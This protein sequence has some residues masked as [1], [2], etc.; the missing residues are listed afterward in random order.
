MQ[1]AQGSEQNTTL[2]LHQGVH[3]VKIR[4]SYLS[5][6]VGQQGVL[7][8]LLAVCSGLEL[9]QVAVVVTLHL[10][11]EDLGLPGRGCGDQVVIQ[12]LKDAGTDVAQLLLNLHKTIVDAQLN[13]R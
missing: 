13:K 6:L 12:Q 2:L 9:R 8:C 11:V 3:E 7:C 5:C 4:F 1:Q 10:Q